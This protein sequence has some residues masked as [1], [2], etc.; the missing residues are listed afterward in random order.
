MSP[1]LAKAELFTVGH[2]NQGI[3]RFVSLLHQHK[4]TALADVRSHPYSRYLPHFNQS[5][6]KA[7]LNREKIYY[8]FLGRNLGARPD[9]PDCYVEGKA[10]YEKI[11]AT[12]AFDEGIQ[13][14]VKGAQQ[15]RI[16]LMC[17][18]K[19]PITCHRAI[20][21]CQHLRKFGLEIKHILSDGSIE[22]HQHLEDRMLVKHGFSDPLSLAGKSQLSLFQQN[23][24]R[25]VQREQDIAQAYQLQG[26]EVA[27]VEKGELAGGKI[28]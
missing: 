20:L 13:R 4:I 8:V 15:Q 27:Y 1:K 3:D 14:I 5:A 9:D 11:A 22:S 17:A 6:L 25:K 28:H 2:S 23:A 7:V 26:G 12:V 21:I 16:A 10:V 24:S 18:E 19:D